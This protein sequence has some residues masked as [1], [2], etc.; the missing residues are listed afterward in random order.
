MVVSRNFCLLLAPLLM[1]G[2]LSCKKTRTKTTTK[3]R[4]EKI[5][6]IKIPAVKVLE[7]TLYNSPPDFALIYC[8]LVSRADMPKLIRSIKRSGHYHTTV[9]VKRNDYDDNLQF[10]VNYHG[11]WKANERGYQFFREEG[12]DQYTIDVDTIKN[13]LEAW[14]GHA[15]GLKSL[16]K[17][18]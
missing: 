11:V 18:N 5:G 13:T 2:V 4:F 10:L 1:M 7:D 3:E 9:Y 6:Y 14:Q 15:G 8:S 12:L 16:K 17:I